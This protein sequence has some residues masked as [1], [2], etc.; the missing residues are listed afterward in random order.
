MFELR[1]APERTVLVAQ[2]KKSDGLYCTLLGEIEF[3]LG[4]Q[5]RRV[6]PGAVFGQRSL[7]SREQR[8]EGF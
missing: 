7:L 4:D 2:G 5:S 1:R 8:S 6:G 3:A